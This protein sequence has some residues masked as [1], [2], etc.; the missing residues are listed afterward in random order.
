VRAHVVRHMRISRM[1]GGQAHGREAWETY[2]G[3]LSA[4]AS[5]M[6]GWREDELAAMMH[7]V[8][9]ASGSLAMPRHYKS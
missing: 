8:V 7:R 1:S 3:P 9:Q 5:V 2:R 6:S 4:A